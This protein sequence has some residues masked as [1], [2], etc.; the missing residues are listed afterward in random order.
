MFELLAALE[1]PLERFEH[2]QLAHQLPYWCLHSSVSLLLERPAAER[3]GGLGAVALFERAA[4]ELGGERADEALFDLALQLSNEPDSNAPDSNEAVALARHGIARYPRSPLL[5]DLHWILGEAARRSW[6]LDEAREAVA[7]G[8]EA[9]GDDAPLQRQYLLVLATRLWIAQGLPELA[10]EPL[11][12]ARALHDASPAEERL[13]EAELVRLEVAWASAVERFDEAIELAEAADPTPELRMLLAIALAERARLEGA[14]ATDAAGVYDALHRDPAVPESIRR[15]AAFGQA[16]LLMEAGGLD[17]ARELIAGV[18]EWSELA[19]LDGRQR[20]ETVRARLELLAGAGRD[21]LAERR[22]ALSEVFEQVLERRA[23]LELRPGGAGLLHFHDVRN[24]LTELL[25]LTRRLDGV[26]AALGELLR[27]RDLGSLARSLGGP[28]TDLAAVRRA[29]PPGAGALA[30]LPG[31]ER[32]HLFLIDAG[33]VRH[34]ELPPLRTWN[35]V[36]RR[37]HQALLAPPR[38]GLSDELASDLQAL[39]EALLPPRV[40][41][42]LAGWSEVCVEGLGLAGYLPIEALPLQDGTALCLAMPTTSWPS[43]VVA[44]R[45]RAAAPAPRAAGPDLALLAAPADVD[46]SPIPWTARHTRRFERRCT[47]EGLFARVGAEVDRAALADPELARA[48]WLL[49]V[50]HGA[51]DPALERPAGFLLGADA[52]G[53]QQ[54]LYCGDL[55]GLEPPPLVFLGIC[56]A[57]RGNLRRG[58]DGVSDL[59]GT[60]LRGGARAVVLSPIDLVFEPTVELAAGFQRELAQGRSPARALHLA[61]RRLVAGRPEYDHPFYYA[62]L[63]LVGQGD[64]EVHGAPLPPPRGWRPRWWLLALALLL[65]LGGWALARSPRSRRATTRT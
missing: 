11:A 14:P 24:A 3:P 41:Q 59:G 35:P 4:V 17:R 6:R 51:Y 64:L 8:L 40:Q 47:R 18:E 27:V 53:Q 60:L 10:L 23:E 48:A 37:V 50:L 29:L 43:L 52:A 46:R 61:R 42:V 30:Y 2:P 13:D 58:D 55:E 26:E 62:V 56:G 63:H 16:E 36:R 20:E 19:D 5:G 44:A 65:A 21:T 12:E 33:A 22:D 9:A 32:T 28:P 49:L 7:R 45:L 1:R 39:S 38:G 54:A 25:E 34:E 57:A 31:P 15:R